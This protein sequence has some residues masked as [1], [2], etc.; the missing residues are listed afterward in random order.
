MEPVGA[1]LDR[2]YR[3]TVLRSWTFNLT[4]LAV[5]ATF[6]TRDDTYLYAPK[7]PLAAL[8]RS[9]L[10]LASRQAGDLVMTLDTCVNRPIRKTVKLGF[11]RSGFEATRLGYRSAFWAVPVL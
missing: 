9:C 11:R 7:R 10:M 5:G 6:K 3:H 2:P 8:S 1:K 4:R